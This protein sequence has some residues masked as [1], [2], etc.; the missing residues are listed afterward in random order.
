MPMQGTALHQGGQID[1]SQGNDLT[2]FNYSSGIKIKYNIN[3]EKIK[4]L[5]LDSRVVGVN[6]TLFNPDV[7]KKSFGFIGNIGLN[8]FK[9]NF[10]VSYWYSTDFVNDFGGYLYSSKSSTVWN[11]NAYEKYRSLLI[12]KINKKIELAPHIILTL[13]AE[14][15]LDLNLNLFEYSY[16]FYITVDEQLWLNKKI[17]PVLTY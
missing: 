10:I 8:A 9:T 7:I 11:P 14:P 13:R 17:K 16:G 6:N 4:S 1:T 3:S 2:N 5:E 15:Y 12:F